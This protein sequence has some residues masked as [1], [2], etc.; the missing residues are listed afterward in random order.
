MDTERRLSDN[1]RLALEELRRQVEHGA[2]I[3]L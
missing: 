3:L 1:H 2:P